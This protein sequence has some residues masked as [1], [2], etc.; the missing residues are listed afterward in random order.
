MADINGTNNDDVIR[1]AALGG[2]LGG[3]PD[4]TEGDDR[5]DSGAGD[6]FV[7]AGGGNDTVASS[8]GLDELDGGD[9]IDTLDFTNAPGGAFIVLGQG[10]VFGDGY[11]NSDSAIN[12]ENALGSDLADD[13]FLAGSGGQNILDGQ[14][15]NDQ[16][17]GGGGDDTLIGG[18]GNDFLVGEED[19]DTLLGGDDNDTLLGGRTDFN[20][21]N[22]NLRLDDLANDFLFGEGGDDTLELGVGDIGEG[23]DGDDVFEFAATDVDPLDAQPL[24]IG[25]ARFAGDAANF[26]IF[27]ANGRLYVEDTVGAGGIDD[28]GSAVLTP[29]AGPQVVAFLQFDDVTVDVLADV[30]GLSQNQ[31]PVGQPIVLTIDADSGVGTAMLVQDPEGDS[32]QFSGY[33][34]GPSNGTLTDLDFDQGA[35]LLSFSYQPDSG[36][37]GTD[38]F[39]FLFTDDFG[40]VGTG[41]VTINVVFDS[42]LVDFYTVGVGRTLDVVAASGVG[43]N[44]ADVNGD[45]PIGF[46]LVQGPDPAYALNFGAADGSFTISQ[47]APAT[48]TAVFTY[49]ASF[50]G[51]T[52]NT[53]PVVVNFVELDETL[54]GDGN[55]NTIFGYG[56]ADTIDGLGGNDT[57]NAG[58][59]NDTST[60]GAGNDTLI[61]GAGIDTAVFAGA[62]AGYAITQLGSNITITD[63]DASDGDDG[64]DTI[65]STEF[66]QF[67][68]LTYDVAANYDP[69]AGVTDGRLVNTL[70]GTAGFGEN[71][72]FR[73]DDSSSA[74]IPVTAL[75]GSALDFY[76][77]PISQIFVN[78]NGNITFTQAIGQFNPTPLGASTTFAIIA[79]G[80][81][82]LDTRAG[83]V[84]PSAGGNSTGSNL[85]YW[86][87]D[88]TT[89]TFTA[90]WDDVANYS[91]GSSATVA[92]QLQL[93]GRGNDDFDIIYRYE[94]MDA[95]RARRAGFANQD[96]TAIFELPG[97]GTTATG[98][99]DTLIGNTG[100][101][102]VWRFSVRDGAF[103]PTATQDSYVT[104]EDTQL[105]V[106]GPGVLG[107]D[108]DPLGRPL[109]AVLGSNP[110]H[111]TVTF[112]TN[113]SFTYT[114]NADFNGTD[115]FTYQAVADTLG[116]GA[117]TV[118][119]TV[120]GTNDAPRNIGIN[121]STTPEN[122][123]SGVNTGIGVTVGTLSASDPESPLGDL[124]FAL[125]NNAGGR[126]VL[127]GRVLKTA[128]VLDYEAATFHDI[129]VRVTDPQGAFTDQTIRIFVDNINEGPTDIFLTGTQAIFE[130]LPP[131]VLLG[132]L[133]SNDAEGDPITYSRISG[134]VT[135]VGDQVFTSI[136][137]DFEFQTQFTFT[138]RAQEPSGD[139]IERQFT[140][141]VDNLNEAPT[142]VA[143]TAETVVGQPVTF[144]VLG[145]D[146]DPDGDTLLVGDFT[147]PTNGTLILN[148]ADDSFT[149]TPNNDFLG[150]DSFTYSVVDPGGLASNTVT[151]NITVGSGD[152][153]GVNDSATVEEEGQVEID[154]LAN[155][156]LVRPDGT[157]A[158]A[159]DA[160]LFITDF[161]NP[162]HGTLILNIPG[163]TFSYL[164]DDDFYGLDTFTYVIT[165]GFSFSQDITVEIT[166]RNVNDDP[167]QTYIPEYRAVENETLFAIL[168]FF[169]FLVDPDVGLPGDFFRNYVGTTT[170]DQGGT[171][172][173][174]DDFT[175][176]YT[177]PQDFVGYDSFTFVYNDY[178][179]EPFFGNEVENGG[180][181]DAV[182]RINVEAE[183]P[184]AAD[185]RYTITIGQSI[186]GD[187]LANDRSPPG[188]TPLSAAFQG[189][190]IPIDA[191]GF[192]QFNALSSGTFISTYR[193]VDSQGRE[194]LDPAILKI[195]V[196]PEDPPPPPPG[197]GGGSAWG[198]PHFV[199]WDGL[200]Y[201]MQGWGEFVLARA[202]SGDTFEVQIRTAPWYTGAQVTIV[203]AVAA[204]IGTHTLMLHV[205]GTLLVDGVATTVAAGT[206]P[207]LLSGNV[208]VYHEATGR[209]VFS[210]NDTGEQVR[211]D[212]VG[213]TYLNISP[214]I[215]A[216]RANTMEGLLGDYDGS[217][218]NDIQ[219]ADGTVLAQPVNINDLYG[220][221]A[222]D[223]RV[224]DA[225]SLFVYGAGEATADFQV[226]N[227][228]PVP[229]RISDLPTAQVA[230]AAALVAAA[231][232]T[233]PFLAEAAILDILL[234]GDD[235]FIQ[236]AQGSEDPDDGLDVFVPPAPPLIGLVSP[237]GDVAEG[238]AGIATLTFTV[239]RTGNGLD[240]VS[241]GWAVQAVGLGFSNAADHGGVLP[242]GSVTLLVGELEKTFTVEI[243]GDLVAELNEE[244]RV[245]FTSTPAGYTVA[246]ATAQQTVL[247]DDGPMLP[248][249][250]DDAASTDAGDP[251]T[252][253]PLANDSDPIG[254][255]ISVTA[256]GAAANGTVQ[257]VGN[258]LTY[259]P[260]AG[261]SGQDS[262][263]YTITLAGGG[264]DT[265]TITIDVAAPPPA[266]NALPV[267]GT[268]AVNAQ[269]ETALVIPLATLLAN[270]SDPDNDVL[271]VLG[272]QLT[273]ANGTAV[274]DSVAG[275]ITY[276]PNAGFSGADAFTYVITDGTISVPGI[277]N[278]TVAAST[279]NAAPV[280]NNDTAS[281]DEDSVIA[282]S[283][284]GNDTD[285]NG[286]ALTAT[287]LVQA[288]NGVVVLNPDGSFTY[289]PDADF[290]GS[291][292]FSY[293]ASDGT[294]SDTA[295]VQITVNAVNDAPIANPDP[296]AADE[297]SPTLLDVLANDTDI[298]G[299]P[300][301]VVDF[302][303][304][305]TFG[306]VAIVGNQVLYTANPDAGGQQDFF[307][308]VVSDGAGGTA[309]GDVTITI[310]DLADA[311][312]VANDDDATT[313]EDTP[314][315]VAVLANDLDDGLLPLV[316]SITGG[317]ANGTAA[318][319]AAGEIE[320]TPAANFFG[321]DTIEYTVTDDTGLTDTATLTVTIDPV[322][323]APAG[324]ALG[325]AA[326]AEN[327][328][329]GTVVGTLSATDAD[330]DALSYGIIGPAGPFSVVGNQLLVNGALDFETL[331]AYPLT[332]SASDGNGGIATLPVI[333]T[334][335]DVN[336]GGPT[337]YG[338]RFSNN[339]VGLGLAPAG[340][341]F[342]P[343]GNVT[344]TPGT[345]WGTLIENAG[346][347]N[348][349]K[350]AVTQGG[351][352]AA[353]GDVIT[354]ANFV[355]VRLDF[356]NALDRDLTV[357]VI[358][359]KRG[360]ASLAEA[361][362]V[363]GAGDD[364]VNWVFHSNEAGWTNTAA[365][366]AGAGDDTVTISD[367]LRS[368]QDN[369]LLADNA[370]PANGSFWR[371]GYDG[372]FSTATVDGG[373][374]ADTIEAV[375]ATLARLVAL[376]GA[377]NDTIRGGAGADDITGGDDNDLLTGRLGADRFRFDGTDGTDE[378]TDFSAAQGDRVVLAGSDALTLS[379]TGFTFGTTSVTASNG[380]VWTAADFLFA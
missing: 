42:A 337:D 299:G 308:Y 62:R 260:N 118:T 100:L 324:L 270:D 343:G 49:E 236:G 261:F 144:A 53:A 60:G 328:P 322:N 30:P 292:S 85:V 111:G 284:L 130:N 344:V 339:S 353:L 319:T 142:A 314:I 345:A 122:L 206:D 147:N 174:R 171:V 38:S 313:D 59:G 27:I 6:D 155:D 320:Y 24:A 191:N 93:V 367:V 73:N 8:A 289:T 12:F 334:V 316:V 98:D 255:G 193:A 305:P 323:D 372:R 242:S 318:V 209:Y 172:V 176:D 115:S 56:G 57:L 268:D 223:W 48:G 302:A 254:A 67:A 18:T 250:A 183:E 10:D 262:F 181:H 203:E 139:G 274:F 104:N 81:A 124:T 92:F 9:G 199:S 244:V 78:N 237:M 63:I 156:Y 108:A 252:V 332:L 210:D 119:I 146:I 170:S 33:T 101:P 216:G 173:L 335:T 258:L 148:V 286:D 285:A 279:V 131:G 371:P 230:A 127:D 333:I 354:V 14:G 177:P 197:G 153:T 330:G 94:F 61:G 296:V 211:V 113:G 75:F 136:S 40:A 90:T 290:N 20:P 37:I 366:R 253:A 360:G 312:P 228:P 66:L 257:Q 185:D 350:N 281:G 143:D 51:G 167:R 13:P 80:W 304:L 109:T 221:Y 355:D 263:T 248:D 163:E 107:N 276:T 357:N 267:A 169:T 46:A 70:G 23:G 34:N 96:D 74:A 239:F 309:Q 205:D 373:S 180:P 152:P 204:A 117:T 295:L 202:T 224:T 120:N 226:L 182:V 43:I 123:V 241:V 347:W 64:T 294:L 55:D 342:G 135:I 321:T 19:T 288:T 84:V 377:G 91:F 376:G 233:D 358:G 213:G 16:V 44:D 116:S 222:N 361:G 1:T 352:N 102:G 4:A 82:D 72:L 275:T 240:E 192:F 364:S 36:F 245:G 264:T 271:A 266:P 161:T 2:S 83:V 21:F 256:V 47:A 365:I 232:I 69:L 132:T 219:L 140:I 165:D 187:V 379:G 297:G 336:E 105:V 362:L 247:N 368:T 179:V 326:V 301:A 198:D 22:S 338:I 278:V 231:G 374:G 25:T 145:N 287:L 200:Y 380:H 97:S 134:P 166:V 229:L 375:A 329:L 246:S 306:T 277:V 31:G 99:L 15:G 293:T 160:G 68:D 188:D 220:L 28:V 218:A 86:D 369:T 356:T 207:L 280:A 5:I 195:V 227:F 158:S 54:V 50:P 194:S 71:V 184:V 341:F 259:T 349:V 311:P 189:G 307:R 212:G 133:S 3:L 238:N 272:V 208:R 283:V 87:L 249:A 88:D 79:G 149:Y 154:V 351:W 291:D 103:T 112:N 196:L 128:G 265:A 45:G 39:D 129:V 282:G 7:A 370:A 17:Y 340:P 348:S 52:T 137:F 58:A 215:G 175:F 164:P 331:A 186:N 41:T 141:F 225:D 234:T 106:A 214:F 114:P 157:Q 217:F 32:F 327:S 325:N 159:R 150:F 162:L 359:A 76:G 363:T 29:G 178:S 315:V 273:P 378:I 346:T 35:G 125:Q 235:G 65:T 317:P 201:D 89:Q 190:S 121:D 77:L 300:L 151:V 298:D 303:V 168:E 26:S 138:V 243:S 126:F 11:G 110:A 251:V 95:S 269:F 310:G